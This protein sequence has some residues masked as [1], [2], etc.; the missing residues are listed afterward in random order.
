MCLSLPGR[1][2][3]VTKGHKGPIGAQLKMASSLSGSGIGI[4]GEMDKLVAADPSLS[5][6]RDGWR[7]LDFTSAGPHCKSF[8]VSF[9]SR[10]LEYI[11]EI[12]VGCVCVF[13]GVLQP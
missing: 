10:L 1:A 8:R 11:L 2:E 7:W 6:L 4:W 13:V 5:V 3:R 9:R 12:V